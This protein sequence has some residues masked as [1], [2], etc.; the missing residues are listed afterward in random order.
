V[1]ALLSYS[2]NAVVSPGGEVVARVHEGNVGHIV[3]D[4]PL[5]SSREP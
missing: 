4:L 1:T 5:R 3:C 2:C